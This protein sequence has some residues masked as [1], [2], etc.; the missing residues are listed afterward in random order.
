MEKIVIIGG[1]SLISNLVN[2]IS[3][4][5]NFEIIGYTD[6]EK[7]N[8]ISDI[9]YLGNDSIL[10]RLYNQGVKSACV[11][12]GNRLNNTIAKQKIYSRLKEIGFKLPIIKG[13]NVIIH[14]GVSVGEG[15]IIRDAAVIQSNCKIGNLVMIGDNVV[16]S[17]DTT[18]GNYSQVVSG[19][20]VGRG[21]KIGDNVFI[22]FSSVVTNDLIINND[23]VIGAKSLVNKSCMEKGMYFGQPAKLVERF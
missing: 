17:H 7:N 6:Y 12:V 22:G 5:K 2:Y 16:V 19:S 23:C 11:G 3:N 20:V 21:V 13:Q 9:P 8:S 14:H 10:K 18:I 1:G 15:T 4:M